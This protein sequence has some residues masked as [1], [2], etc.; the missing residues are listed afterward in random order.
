MYDLSPSEA[1]K[2]IKFELGPWYKVNH[3]QILCERLIKLDYS[4]QAKRSEAIR[5]INQLN[6]YQIVDIES[7]F[8]SGFYILGSDSRFLAF[9]SSIISA[10][11]SGRQ[12]HIEIKLKQGISASE[13][14]VA[15]SQHRYY[16]AVQEFYEF[17]LQP[18]N[19]YYTNKF[20]TDNDFS[21][22]PA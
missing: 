13:W 7:R 6:S 15:D 18:D 16:H 4:L 5:L 14:G 10:L 1:S 19:I 11:A 9:K 17:I 20:E 22:L 3:L 8:K 21:W 12:R 2:F